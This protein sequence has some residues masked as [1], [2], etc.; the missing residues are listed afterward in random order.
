MQLAAG[1]AGENAVND[2]VFLS[3][4]FVGK[5]IFVRVQE[6]YEL[7]GFRPPDSAQS[8]QNVATA[9]ETMDA[10]VP[11]AAPEEPSMEEFG[12]LSDSG[13]QYY[14]NYDYFG[15]ICAALYVKPMGDRVYRLRCDND[16]EHTG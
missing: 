12:P 11:A 13:L 8:N 2:G 14:L 5:I 7:D 1:A 15:W 9:S 10:S 6:G 3:T 16:M 4:D